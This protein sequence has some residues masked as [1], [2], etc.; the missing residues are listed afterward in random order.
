M[1]RSSLHS[2]AARLTIMC[3]DICA[4]SVQTYGRHCAT[5]RRRALSTMTLFFILPLLGT[6]LKSNRCT[7]ASTLGMP[8]A[9]ADAALHRLYIGSLPAARCPRR[10]RLRWS[11]QCSA[12]LRCSHTCAPAPACVACMCGHKRVQTRTCTRTAG[13]SARADHR[14]DSSLLACKSTHA[15]TPARPPARPHTRTHPCTQRTVGTSV[16]TISI[17]IMNK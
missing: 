15:R 7:Y 10:S 9:V 13:T 14:C 3:I 2:T 4:T 1:V 5:H 17:M 11:S 16:A 12:P 6:V 8:S